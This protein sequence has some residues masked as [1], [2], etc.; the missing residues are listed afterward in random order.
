MGP[1]LGL[2]SAHLLFS[3]FCFRYVN[4]KYRMIQRILASAKT[5]HFKDKKRKK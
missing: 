2:F 5:V 3:V 1:R 4:E